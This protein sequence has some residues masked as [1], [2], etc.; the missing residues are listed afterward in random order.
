[1]KK[2]EKM[3]EFFNT[4]ASGY[5]NHMRTNVDAFEKLY[6]KIVDPIPFSE[7]VKKVLV[8]G[9]GTGLEVE[10]IFKKLPNALI[11]GIDLSADMLEQLREKYPKK[12][13]QIELIVD[14][15]TEHDLGNARFDY[16]VSV[17]TVHHLLEDEKLA[18]Y[19][20]ILSA[21]KPEGLYL[22][23]DFVVSQEEAARFL[24]AYFRIKEENK[25]EDMKYYHVDIPF[26]VETQKRLFQEAG[27][28][29]FEIIFQEESASIFSNKK[30]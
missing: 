8:L 16:C 22:E 23:G 9:C 21:L 4:R 10:A 2:P 3:N 27:F 7:E 6:T 25:I 20:K 12:T 28:V 18:L 19:R 1:M 24:E 14:S 29:N 30:C 26:T 11:T 15:Y 5:D 13:D 17:M